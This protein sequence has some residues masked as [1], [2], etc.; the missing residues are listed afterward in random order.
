M[1]STLKLHRPR[2]DRTCG[3]NISHLCLNIMHPSK[4][5]IMFRFHVSFRGCMIGGRSHHFPPNEI[6]T[7]FVEGN[8]AAT[9]TTTT[10]STTTTT[11]TT[12]TTLQLR[13]NLESDFQQK[14]ASGGDEASSG[15]RRLELMLQGEMAKGHSLQLLTQQM[16][17]WQTVRHETVFPIAWM[18][19]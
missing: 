18:Y 7:H 2:D 9:T 12:T 8:T 14:T 16:E 19:P 11:T 6:C 13:F 3:S 1:L 15:L 4:P 17:P 10:T 5:S